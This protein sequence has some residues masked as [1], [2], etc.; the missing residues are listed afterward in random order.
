VS[1]DEAC[2]LLVETVRDLGAARVRAAQLEEEC[3]SSRELRCAAL[4]ALA[5]VTADRDRLRQQNGS[6][7]SEIRRFTAAV[8][9]TGRAA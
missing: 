5:D 3:A 6:L 9:A 4:D 1:T 8:V 2:A 7:R